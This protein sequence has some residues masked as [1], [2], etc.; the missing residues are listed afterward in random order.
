MVRN[1]ILGD[2]IVQIDAYNVDTREDTTDEILEKFSHY[3]KI[4]SV[5]FWCER[6]FND[7]C[8][9][10]REFCDDIDH[11]LKTKP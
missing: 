4:A 6:P 3:A 2:H 9:T 11:Y 5:Y 8:M 7:E 1:L 10:A